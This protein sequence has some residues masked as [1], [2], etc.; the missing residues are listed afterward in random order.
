MRL[1]KV[2]HAKQYIEENPQ[3]VVH[4]PKAQKGKWNKVFRNENPIHIEIGCGKGKFI[5]ELAQANPN[6]NYIGIEKFDSVIVRA[7]EKLIESPLKN[8]RLIRIDA[9]LLNDIFAL[10]EVASIYLNFSDPWPKNRQ[11]KRRLTSLRFLSIYEKILNN[12]AI[13][14]FKTDN[15][16]LFQYSMMTLNKYAKF[17]IENIIINLYKNLPKNNVQTEFEMKFVEM[18]KLIHYMK[19]RF[20]GD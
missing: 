4:T 10:G 9:E 17:H 15:F 1:R 2:K 3:I 13:I 5:T 19:V 20:K 14:Q 18:G 16:D 6:I 12:E 11:E 8:I 7:I